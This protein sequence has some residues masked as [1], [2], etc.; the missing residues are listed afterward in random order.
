[1][2]GSIIWGLDARLPYPPYLANV[3]S[4]RIAM[5]PNIQYK[6]AISLY[7]GVN[8]VEYGHPFW[9]EDFVHLMYV[10]F[11]GLYPHVG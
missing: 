3:F 5:D 6:L 8:H 4:S 2:F 7:V 1:M 9:G 10:C 11:N